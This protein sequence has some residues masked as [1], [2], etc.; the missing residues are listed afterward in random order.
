M[1]LEE[2]YL[3]VRVGVWVKV[4][5]TFRVGGGNQAIV[6]EENCPRL[7]LGFGL[8]MKGKELCKEL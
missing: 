3:Q 5:V 2:N 7:G 6:P 1:P 8:G 4:R